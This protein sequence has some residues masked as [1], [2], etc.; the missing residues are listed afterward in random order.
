MTLKGFVKKW[1][2]TWI[3]DH[4]IRRKYKIV[5][6]SHRHRELTQIDIKFEYLED[7]EFE[8][9]FKQYRREERQREKKSKEIEKDLF[10]QIKI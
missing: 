7:R 9:E 3:F 8:K 5:F 2:S 6:N 10:D 4:W 1:N